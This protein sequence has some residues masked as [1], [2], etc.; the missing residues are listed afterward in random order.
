MATHSLSITI[1]GLYFNFIYHI[2]ETPISLT[3]VLKDSY[4]PDSLHINPHN[5]KILFGSNIGMPFKTCQMKD[6]YSF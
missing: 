1:G 6:K 4:I 3:E 2:F 5:S